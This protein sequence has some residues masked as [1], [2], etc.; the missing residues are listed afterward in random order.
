MPWSG[1]ALD[2]E[3]TR[4]EAVNA[5]REHEERR[6]ALAADIDPAEIW[7][8]AQGE[9]ERASALWFAQLIWDDPDA[10]RVAA[11]GRRIL[12]HKTHFKFQPPDFEIHPEEKVAQRM[13]EESIRQERERIVSAGFTFFHGLWEA[14]TKGKTPP[15]PDPELADALRDVLFAAMADNASGSAE[16]TVW[17]AVRKG[18]PDS[19]HLALFLAQTWGV[20]PMHYNAQLL[21]EG[22]DWGDEWSHAY[23]ADIDALLARLESMRGEPEGEP[24]V[25]IDSATTH[26]IDDAFYIEPGEG[27][28]YRLQIALAC[29]AL[30]WEFGS[31]LDR[32]VRE[33]ASSIY[34]P[35]ASA[36]CCP[37]V[38]ASR[39]SACTKGRRA[40]R[41]SWT[42]PWTPR[43]NCRAC[44]RARRG[45]A[46][47]ATA[48]TTPWRRPWKAMPRT[49][50]WPWPTNWGTSCGS[51]ASTRARW[52]WTGPTR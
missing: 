45:C 50:C 38:T 29:P 13:A 36:T 47:K 37:S 30:P 40:R 15:Q 8:L 35:R 25:S 18:L 9:V 49:R 28:G 14:R 33:R 41:W 31:P 24:Y 12:E 43:E 6:D 3:A 39:A 5:L 2:A 27:G 32:A 19:P 21:Q 46:S 26:D 1:P 20:V 17:A 42:A 48:P 10:D 44:S 16:M 51:G 34:L 7:E 4:E 11:M 23:D 22:Y 52:W